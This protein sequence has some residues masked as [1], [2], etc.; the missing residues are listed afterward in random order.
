MFAVA[1]ACGVAMESMTLGWWHRVWYP[2]ATLFFLTQD[3][4][5]TRFQSFDAIVHHT[6]LRSRREPD[7]FGGV[8]HQFRV[9]F[10]I[11]QE[12]VCAF[13]HGDVL[14]ADESR[15]GGTVDFHIGY[16]EKKNLDAWY[17]SCLEFGVA[18][19]DRDVWIGRSHVYCRLGVDQSIGSTTDRCRGRGVSYGGVGGD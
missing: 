17:E 15:D 5:H 19:G 3:F 10:G 13:E 7:S 14:V 8:T 16:V 4:G 9:A 2:I 1:L 18:L 6:Q 12:S 11:D